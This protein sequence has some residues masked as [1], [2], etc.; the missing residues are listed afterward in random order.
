LLLKEEPPVLRLFKWLLAAGLLLLLFVAASR[1]VSSWREKLAFGRHH[2]QLF[3]T[4]AGLHGRQPLEVDKNTW[5]EAVYLTTTAY[6]NVCYSP[7][8][9]S[10][11]EMVRLRNDLDEKLKSKVGINTLLWIW[12]RLAQ[13]GPHGRQYITRFK[14][15]LHAIVN[16]AL[17]G[18]VP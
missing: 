13:T 17:A 5:E 12:D 1:F 7:E 8:H 10:N 3:D 6:G 2:Y 11:A 9:V 18:A 16:P 4:I 15:M 14:P